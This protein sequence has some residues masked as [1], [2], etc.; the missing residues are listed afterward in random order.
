[1]WSVF[2][3]ISEGQD[4]ISNYSYI[5]FIANKIDL[6][7]FFIFSR[8]LV[9]ALMIENTVFNRTCHFTSK[10]IFLISKKSH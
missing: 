1:M 3:V 6:F 2:Q 9:K 5:T 4:A 10:Y 8:H 7:F